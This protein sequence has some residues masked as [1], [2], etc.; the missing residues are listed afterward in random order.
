MS[1]SVLYM[2]VGG[3][4]ALSVLLYITIHILKSK[5]KSVEKSS[6]RARKMQSLKASQPQEGAERSFIPSGI[7]AE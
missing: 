6:R 3:L 4:I 7:N 2:I 1:M 5:K